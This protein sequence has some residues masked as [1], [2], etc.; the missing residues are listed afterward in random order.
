MDSMLNQQDNVSFT[1]KLEGV[2]TAH[3][4]GCSEGARNDAGYLS[5]Y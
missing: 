4:T 1:R 2:K 5:V 3:K